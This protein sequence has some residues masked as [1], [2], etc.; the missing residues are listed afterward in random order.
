MRN[1]HV[2]HLLIPAKTENKLHEVGAK[3]D[4][5]QSN[6]THRIKKKKHIIP[7]NLK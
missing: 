7:N 5:K 1:V 2:K 3:N 4:T 6:F